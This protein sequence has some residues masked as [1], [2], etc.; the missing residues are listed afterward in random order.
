MLGDGKR[1]PKS[2]LLR[3][4]DQGNRDIFAECLTFCRYKGRPIPSIRRRRWV[5]YHLLFQQ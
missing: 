2:R 1:T 5:E 4:L 3:K